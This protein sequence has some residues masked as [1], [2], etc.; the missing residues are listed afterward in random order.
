[1]KKILLLTEH[2]NISLNEATL[3]TV[4]AAAQIGETD[5]LVAGDQCQGGR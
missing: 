4:T 2:D 1:M 3:R 5:I